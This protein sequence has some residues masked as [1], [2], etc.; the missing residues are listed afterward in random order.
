MSWQLLVVS[1]QLSVVGCRLAVGSRQSAVGSRRLSVGSRPSAVGGRRLRGM[2][3]R[4]IVFRLI[5]YGLWVA[6]LITGCRVAAIG[7]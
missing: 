1:C 5:G 4:L 3:F 2:G 7:G 6:G